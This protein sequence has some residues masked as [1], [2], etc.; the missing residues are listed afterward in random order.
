M[1]NSLGIFKCESCR[2]CFKGTFC[3][4]DGN[5]FLVDNYYVGIQAY[6]VIIF[7]IILFA[8]SRCELGI[9]IY[10][11]PVNIVI[12]WDDF[13][14]TIGSDTVTVTA[15]QGGRAHDVTGEK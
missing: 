6:A 14:I 5:F 4:I 3:V 11:W 2:V 15:P 8:I 10:W 12:S 9:P 1:E 7:V 13:F